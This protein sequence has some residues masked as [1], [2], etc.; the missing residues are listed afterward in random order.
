MAPM[1]VTESRALPR[2]APAL[3]GHVNPKIATTA[4]QRG[5]QQRFGFNGS[6][7]RS[8]AEACVS[9]AMLTDADV[10]RAI[11]TRRES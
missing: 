4:R 8:D 7:A 2:D 9:R 11:S 5:E 10:L 1:G 3:F 6:D